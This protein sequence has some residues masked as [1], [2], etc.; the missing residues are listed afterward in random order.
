MKVNNLKNCIYI[1]SLVQ[2][3]SKGQILDGFGGLAVAHKEATP[4]EAQDMFVLF[5]QS[6]EQGEIS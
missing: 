3:A 4:A 1:V 5:S 2:G 6:L